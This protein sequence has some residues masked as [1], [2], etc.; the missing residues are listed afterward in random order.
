M[1]IVSIPGDEQRK[2]PYFV[3][4]TGALLFLTLHFGAT[5]SFVA[6][7]LVGAIHG[8]TAWGVSE[9][10][11]LTG[12]LFVA[13]IV[14]VIRSTLSRPERRVP[15]GRWTKPVGAR[16]LLWEYYERT[17]IPIRFFWDRDVWKDALD[18]AGLPAAW[19]IL[20]PISIGIWMTAVVSVLPAFFVFLTKAG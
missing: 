4:R 16:N 6:E 14:T 20:R 2:A 15:P 1:G 8:W 11:G 19:R 7:C 10:A 13:T 17:S 12:I 18:V 5:M 9:L 3:G